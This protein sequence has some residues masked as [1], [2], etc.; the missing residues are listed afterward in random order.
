[1]RMASILTLTANTLIDCLA[2]GQVRP[3]KVNRVD[4]FELVAGGKG[5]N[6]GRVLASFGHRVVAAGFAGG[7]SGELLKERVQANGM[8]P[9]LVPTEART[10]IGF[11]VAGSEGG[12]AFLENGFKVR[13]EEARALVEAI[14]G[15]LES[16]QLVLVSGSIPDES[17]VGLYATVLDACAQAKVP[18]WLDAYGPAL[19][20]AL[21]RPSPPSLVK[22]NRDEYGDGRGFDVCPELHVTDG[23]KEVEVRTPGAHFEI[24]PPKL[25]ERSAIG[26]GDCYFAA[27]AHARLTGLP[28]AEQL[29][30]A[31][32]AGA[33]NAA[34]GATARIGL[35]DV[36]PWL[37]KVG[38]SR[39]LDA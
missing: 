9:M 25:N 11:N 21:A 5:L 24:V 7:W 10:R 2:T 28:E 1:D 22:C 32:A 34:M 15:R 19:Q 18:C 37:A 36:E 29:R 39:R 20:K 23:A 30:W 16:V 8:E 31:A 4:Q 26:S 14:R 3:S 38:V 35:A 6:A 13:P 12:I 17:C 27:L 33:A